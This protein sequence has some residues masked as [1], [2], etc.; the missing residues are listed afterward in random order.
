MNLAFVPKNNHI[1]KS[2]WLTNIAETVDSAISVAQS[3]VENYSHE[4]NWQICTQE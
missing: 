3:S 4:K 1:E 2:N